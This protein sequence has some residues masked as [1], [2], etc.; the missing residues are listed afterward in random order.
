ML[1]IRC[2]N[3]I[4]EAGL[5]QFPQASYQFTEQAGAEDAILVRSA[6]LKEM[7][8]GADLKAIA[9]AGAGTNNIPTA[10]CSEAGIVVFN[11]PGANANAV[12]ELV[13]A[14]LL[15]SSRPVV[16][17]IAWIESLGSAADLAQRVEKEKSRFVGTELKGKTLGVIGLGAIGILIANLAAELDMQVVGYDP[18]ISVDAAWKFSRQVR[19]VESL[20]AVLKTADYVTIHVPLTPQTKNLIAA[21]QLKLMKTGAV[22]LNFARG[23]LV[24]EDAV[25]AALV[26][27]QI[28][29]YV[30]DFPSPALAEKPGVTLIPHL[31]ASTEEAEENCAVMAAQE[32]IDYL[33]NGNI[34][35]AVNLPDVVMERSGQARLCCFHRNVPNMLAH[36]SGMISKQGINIENLLNRSQGEFAYTL[37]D[38]DTP[39]VEEIAAT[40]RQQPEILRVRVIHD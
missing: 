11:T 38:V 14:G 10:R 30:T 34:R 9:R 4:A 13:L 5:V 39:A 32:L 20:E 16:P 25:L 2:L 33:E 36:I 18:Y 6:D 24:Q 35:N 22:L 23:G 29:G 28:R 1:N 31:G 37:V 3:K 17:A 19:H 7:E 40:L 21:G 27:R 26:A 15:M 8:F 12:K